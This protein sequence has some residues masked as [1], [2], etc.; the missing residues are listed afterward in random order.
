ME[1]EKLEIK[2]KE[3]QRNNVLEKRC[4]NGM[5]LCDTDSFEYCN[6]S[7]GRHHTPHTKCYFTLIVLHTLG[8]DIV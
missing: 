8:I 3:R 7:D 4:E 2:G 5:R 6:S 1:R